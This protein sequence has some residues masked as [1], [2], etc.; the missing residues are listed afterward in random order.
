MV[1]ETVSNNAGASSTPLRSSTAANL[2]SDI[3]DAR[4]IVAAAAHVFSPDFD[5]ETV[6][7]AHAVFKSLDIAIETVNKVLETSTGGDVHQ[8]DAYGE[9]CGVEALLTLLAAAGW[10]KQWESYPF[11][12]DVMWSLLRRVDQ[13]L[14]VAIAHAE[15]HPVNTIA[16]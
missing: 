7:P 15:R 11:P 3:R 12:H 8:E 6:P 10:E 5:R 14:C 13:Q 9:L 2:A 4:A 1:T 16:H